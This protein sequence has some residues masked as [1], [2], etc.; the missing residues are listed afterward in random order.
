MV[1]GFPEGALE[2]KTTFRLREISLVAGRIRDAAMAVLE[3]RKAAET[4]L[5]DMRRLNE[6]STLLMREEN[7]SE[8]CFHEIVK[9][10]I[11]LSG[12]DKGNM[13]LFDATS[14][15][16]KI[17]SQYGFQ[18]KFLKFFE[19]VASCGAAMASNEQVTVGDILT[20]EIFVGQP[21]QKVL[22]ESDVR[23]CVSTPLR[24]SKGSLLG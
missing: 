7:D 6:L 14:Q 16:L 23:A 3:G 9:T 4:E 13:Q 8:T 22:L 20:S 21:A 19:S 15:S 5:R 1:R 12:A 24:S 18:V 11:G 17:V 10:A 2:Q